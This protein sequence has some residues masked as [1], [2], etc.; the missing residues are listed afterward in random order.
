MICFR[1]LK[2]KNI[3]CRKF[4]I[5]LEKNVIKFEAFKI[6]K[7]YGTFQVILSRFKFSLLIFL[8]KKFV[9]GV[10]IYSEPAS[11]KVRGSVNYTTGVHVTKL[12]HWLKE[13]CINNFMHWLM[14]LCINN[15]MHWLIQLCINNFMHWI[16]KVCIINFMHWIL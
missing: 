5:I 13:L 12:M 15:F 9:R 4:F 7:K 16:I 1:R 8:H 11:K 14:Q 10:Q 3:Y 2:Q 6:V